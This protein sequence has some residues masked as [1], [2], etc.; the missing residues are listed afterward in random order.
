MP[1]IEGLDNAGIGLDRVANIL[2]SIGEGFGPQM[3]RRA[4]SVEAVYGMLAGL[5]AS[6]TTAGD[7]LQKVAADLRNA[8]AELE[9][10]DET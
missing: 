1:K 3:G 4:T 5:G 10:L 9:S 2:K 6:L 7:E 8:A